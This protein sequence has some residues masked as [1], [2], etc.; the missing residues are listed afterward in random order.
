[1]QLELLVT[2]S[3]PLSWMFPLFP[4]AIP[5][6]TI[7]F[8]ARWKAPQLSVPCFQM[9]ILFRTLHYQDCFVEKQTFTLYWT[10]ISAAPCLCRIRH[11]ANGQFGGS[12]VLLGRRASRLM[13]MMMHGGRDC[14]VIHHG[15]L[16]STVVAFYF[17]ASELAPSGYLIF[18]FF[19]LHVVAHQHH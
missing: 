12:K 16:Y 5:L 10:I 19:F 15:S 6:L 2:V 4:V 7:F 14:M 17:T 13:L 1:M 18:S 8:L 9:F 11:S 3:L